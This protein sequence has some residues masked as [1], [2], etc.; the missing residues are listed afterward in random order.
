MPS[1]KAPLRDLKFVMHEV[2]KAPEALKDMPYYAGNETADSDLIDQVM[3]EAARFAENELVAA[4]RGGR[5]GRL[6]P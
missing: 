6:Y 5:S 3:E 2:L 1:Y 4:Q